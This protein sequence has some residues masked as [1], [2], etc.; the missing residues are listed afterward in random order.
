MQL[1][2]DR[3]RTSLRHKKAV[4]R[5]SG[6]LFELNLSSLHLTEPSPNPGQLSRWSL[7][8]LQ[9]LHL[10]A[11]VP[12]RLRVAGTKMEVVTPFWSLRSSLL[13]SRFTRRVRRRSCHSS[14]RLFQICSVINQNRQVVQFQIG[15]M[16]HPYAYYSRLVLDFIQ[17][18]N[19]NFNH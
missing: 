9:P 5:I 16:T 10:A 8:S 6:W 4:L 14:H 13:N 3:T 15:H 12:A 7:F 18:K 11:S 19:L 17:N 2:C 1:A